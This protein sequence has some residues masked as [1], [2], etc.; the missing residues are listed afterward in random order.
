MLDPA[1]QIAFN[2]KKGS[3]PMRTDVDARAWTSAR[4]GAWRSLK[5]PSQAAAE[6][7]SI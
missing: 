7:T 4:K 3:V 2:T 1:A 6:A 5:D